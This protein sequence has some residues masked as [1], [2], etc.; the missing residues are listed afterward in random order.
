MSEFTAHAAVHLKRHYRNSPFRIHDD[1]ARPLLDNVNKLGYE[2]LEHI[3][4]KTF[5]KVS[6][7]TIHQW[8][9]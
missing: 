3:V 7:T 8:Q 5:P 9:Y 1:T 4:H 6:T 2:R